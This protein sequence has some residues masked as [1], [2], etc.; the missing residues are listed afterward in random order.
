MK[1]IKTIP[2]TQAQPL[3]NRHLI[4]DYLQEQTLQNP[5]ATAVRYDKQYLTY[6]ALNNSVNQLAHYL[7][8]IGVQKGTMIAI[9]VE[10]SL[11]M[12][13]GILGI[14]RAGGVYDNGSDSGY[15]TFGL[16]YANPKLGL[17]IGGR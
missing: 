2:N 10:R 16:G 6:R 1:D 7:Q 3:L 9:S 15:V 11:E 8:D 4:T 12:M 13:I 14:L 17:D 5:K